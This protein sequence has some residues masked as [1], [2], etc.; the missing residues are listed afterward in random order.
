MN[1]LEIHT[2]SV[3]GC[4]HISILKSK[5]TICRMTTEGTAASCDTLTE[6]EIEVS[7]S[8]ITKEVNIRL[9]LNICQDVF[10]R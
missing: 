9:H 4:C 10:L 6:K 3:H 5:G 8:T 2:A 7:M 1:I